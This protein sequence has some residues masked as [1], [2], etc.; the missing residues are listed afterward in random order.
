METYLTFYPQKLLS[1]HGYMGNSSQPCGKSSIMMSPSNQT[2]SYE[3][4]SY[5]R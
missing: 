4:V 3:L 1:Y 5:S 2:D